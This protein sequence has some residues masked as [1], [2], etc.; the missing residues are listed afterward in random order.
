MGY[1]PETGIGG[2]HGVKAVLKGGRPGRTVALWADID[3]LPIQEE[4]GLPY[5]C[6]R[7]R[8]GWRERFER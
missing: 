1:E 5:T 7:R 3:A 8:L 2:V 6:W 4:T